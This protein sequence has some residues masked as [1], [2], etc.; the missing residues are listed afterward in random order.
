MKP[1]PPLQAK[2][3]HHTKRP[4]LLFLHLIVTSTKHK[5]SQSNILHFLRFGY[6]FP[7]LVIVEFTN[8]DLKKL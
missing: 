2:H 6:V 4:I 8:I 5:K 7:V 3:R 1:I